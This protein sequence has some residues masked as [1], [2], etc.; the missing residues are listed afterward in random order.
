MQ[1]TDA[2]LSSSS[3]IP[4]SHPPLSFIPAQFF[5]PHP[6]EEKRNIFLLNDFLALLSCILQVCTFR[7]NMFS[8]RQEVQMRYNRTYSV[9]K[10][11]LCLIRT[12]RCVFRPLLPPSSLLLY[13]IIFSFFLM[14]FMPGSSISPRLVFTRSDRKVICC[15][16]QT[17]Q[18]AFHVAAVELLQKRLSAPRTFACFHA[19]MSNCYFWLLCTK[20]AQ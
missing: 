16:A 11:V 7:E 10:K 19:R 18:I 5:S 3:L 15:N 20:D 9:K 1:L 13:L 4:G 6:I 8:R 12:H 2:S 17:G 14:C